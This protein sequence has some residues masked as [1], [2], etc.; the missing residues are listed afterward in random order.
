M[1][2]HNAL[3][4]EAP[5]LASRMSIIYRAIDQLK[6]DPANPHRH[7]TK[8]IRQIANSISVFDFNV[9]ILIVPVGVFDQFIFS[10][11]D[12]RK[13]V[14]PYVA[15]SPGQYYRRSRPAARVS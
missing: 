15:G 4:R 9:P 12:P 6:P 8:Q 11:H 3:R 10:D 13:M 7:S 5:G 2:D 1:K 14:R